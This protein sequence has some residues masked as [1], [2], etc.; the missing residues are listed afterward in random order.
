[1][2]KLI[3]TRKMGARNGGPSGPT[4]LVFCPARLPD[5]CVHSRVRASGSGFLISM[6]SVGDWMIF[7]HMR[8]EA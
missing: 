8:Q 4:K 1:M 2:Q 5:P 3:K 6:A 7:G